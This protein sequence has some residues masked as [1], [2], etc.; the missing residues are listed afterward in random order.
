MSYHKGMPE[1]AK[2]RQ[3]EDAHKSYAELY[4]EKYFEGGTTGLGGGGYLQYG[5]FP[6]MGFFLE[7]IKIINPSSVL[8]LGGGRGYLVKKLNQLGIV[9]CNLDVSEYCYRTRVT[10]SFLLHDATQTPWPFKDKQFDLCFSTSFLEHIREKDTFAL[11]KEIVRVSNRS[12]HHGAI[13]PDGMYETE[14]VEGSDPTHVTMKPYDWWGSLFR[15]FEPNYKIE[16]IEY[17]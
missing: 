13:L 3:Q 17:R 14:W 15:V 7:L 4:D 12:L 16:F 6:H 8:E 11:V 5:D 10:D 9:A 1:W 2:K